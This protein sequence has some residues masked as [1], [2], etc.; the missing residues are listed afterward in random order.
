MG[1]PRGNVTLL[2]EFAYCWG[3][4]DKLRSYA[5][6]PDIDPLGGPTS[7]LGLILNNEPLALFGAGGGGSGVHAHSAVILGDRI[8]LAVG[9]SLV[10][11]DLRERETV[12]TTRVDSALCFGIYYEPVRHALI[13]H[14]EL[15]IARIGLDGR[16]LWQSGGADVFSGGFRLDDDAIVAIDFEQATY[17]F[18]YETGKSTMTRAKHRG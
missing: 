14:G 5:Q 4:G 13:S 10:C 1:C 15:E 8:F 7:M 3:K 16:V 18:D 17:R 9:D 2:D 12:W 11:Y 6:E